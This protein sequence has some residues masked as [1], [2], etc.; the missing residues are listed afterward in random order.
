MDLGKASWGALT[1]TKQR[2][3]DEVLQLWRSKDMPTL[4][5]TSVSCMQKVKI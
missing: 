4:S 3:M 2:E 1:K 5:A